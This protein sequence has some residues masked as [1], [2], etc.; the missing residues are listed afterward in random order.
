M[1]EKIPKDIYDAIKK[2]RNFCLNYECDFCPLY[3]HDIECPCVLFE[4]PRNW[5]DMIKYLKIDVVEN[6]EGDNKC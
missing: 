4:E 5:T 6:N 2:I 1:K 3:T